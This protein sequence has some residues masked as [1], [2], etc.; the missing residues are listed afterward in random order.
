M[1]CAIAGELLVALMQLLLLLHA[2]QLVFSCPF[3]AWSACEAQGPAQLLSLARPS[4]PC[5]IYLT[6]TL[7]MLGVSPLM[8]HFQMSAT[9]TDMVL[10]VLLSLLHGAVLADVLMLL[11]L[12]YAE[13][14]TAALSS[15]SFP[16]EGAACTEDRQP[17]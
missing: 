17:L 14:T 4:R 1:V 13:L 3:L 16:S 10:L 12:V 9:S 7:R 8:R 6:A 2:E 15:V 11:I 5:E